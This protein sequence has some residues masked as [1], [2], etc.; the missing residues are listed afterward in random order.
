MDNSG[1]RQAILV[2]LKEHGD[3][4]LAEVAGHLGVT[5]QGALRHV[6]GLVD[7]GL[8]QAITVPGEGPGRPR[9]H[10]RL[11]DAARAAFPDSHRELAAE[12]VEF[13]PRTELDRFFEARAA[14]LERDYASRLAG[15]NFD[16]KVRELAR[17]ASAAGHMAE[18]VELPAGGLAIRHCN[19]PIGEV[20]ARAESPCRHEQAMYERLLGAPVERSTWLPEQGADCTYEIKSN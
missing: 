13:L 7:G 16:E 1:R 4:T 19:C 12:L 17:L 14:R 2:F 18:V 3:A 10:Y 8:V 5:K 9:H 15:L 20:A 11:T 6:D